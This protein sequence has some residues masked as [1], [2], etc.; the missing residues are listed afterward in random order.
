VSADPENEFFADGI[1]E[2]V[3]A[4]LSRIRALTVISRTSVMAF[5][6]RE[7]GLRETAAALMAGNVV[8]GSVRRVADRVRIVAQLINAETD[9]CLWSETYDRQLTDVFEIQTDVAL[10]IADALQT[11]LSPEESSRIRKEPTRNVEAY[12]LYLKGRHCHVQFTTE[13]MLQAVDHFEHAIRLDPDYALAHASVAMSYLELAETGGLEP[14]HA[15]RRA[16][17]AAAT[18]LALDPGLSEA[19][20][21][22]GTLK[23]GSEFDWSGA[24]QEF[25]RALELSPSSADTY[26]VYGRMCAGLERYDEAIAMLK[27]AQEL[28]PLAHRSDLATALLRAG[29]YDEALDT[30][31]RSVA[32]EP[33][34]DR[35]RATLGWAFM[36]KGMHAEGIVEL[37]RATSISPEN[38]TW[39]AQLGQAY[40]ET[41]R[42]DEARAVLHQLQELSKRRYVS[43]FHLAYVYT[44]LGQYDDAINALESAIEERSG[45]VYA[46]KGSFLF[47]ALRPNPRFQA[48][49]DR[50]NVK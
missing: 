35:G 34:Y 11:Q 50:I 30:A 36:L 15:Y 4:H 21:I 26:D 13:G 40:A 22:S 9:E 18:A 23:L 2:D 25:K 28:D 45:A 46:I 5:K 19:H 29:R 27:R 42:T 3:I 6:K 33:N 1:T 12:Q 7:Q 38:T 37:E 24:E 47:R 16:K 17:T 10:N 39:L 31:K 43:P 44:G 8:E 14:E 20:T 41:G 48:L 49:L 32:A